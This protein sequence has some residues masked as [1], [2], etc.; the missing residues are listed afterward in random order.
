MEQAAKY[1]YKVFLEKSI[2]KAAGKLFIS[3]PALSAA[4]ARHEKELGFQIFNRSTIP[5]SLTPKGQIYIDSLAQILAI[6]RETDQRLRATTDTEFRQIA[7]GCT[8]SIA[9]YLLP[10]ICDTFHQKHPEVKITV[11]LGNNGNSDNL[12]Q[13]LLRNQIDFYICDDPPNIKCKTL[14]LLQE[15]LLIA[16]HKQIKIPQALRQCAVSHDGLFDQEHVPRV[17]DIS[18][19]QDIPFI[20]YYTGTVMY[21]KTQA[22]V[23][24]HR[25]APIRIINAKNALF[26][27][28]LASRGVGAL[29]MRVS[30]A[31]EVFTREDDLSYFLLDHEAAKHKIYLCSNTERKHTPIMQDFLSVCQSIC[32]EYTSA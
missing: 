27:F 19:F 10:R 18:L 29:I 6:E 13:K 30:A 17:R 28:R 4:I 3:Q 22:I 8:N 12:P 2:T 16:I 31:K 15:P 26:H 11:D 7:V 5:L 23:G 9:Y 25:A 24:N 20:D 32:G 21:K 14:L 1:V